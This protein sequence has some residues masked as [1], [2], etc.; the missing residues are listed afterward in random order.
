MRNLVLAGVSALA[1]GVL[2]SP[3]ADAAFLLIDDTDP[4]TITVTAGDFEGGFSIDGTELTIGL[5]ASASI[6]LPDGGYSISGSWLDLGLGGPRADVLFALTGTPSDVTSGIEF[7]T[8]TDGS[9]STLFGSL[10]GFTGSAYFFTALPTL[11]QGAVGVAGVPFLS[12]EFRSEPVA[13]V[14]APMSLALF[15][16]A[17][18]GLAGIRRRG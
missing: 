2:A 5:G 14:P 9:S 12:V 17:L 13:A 6:T 11:T 10:G 8:T 18:L 7:G 16:V 15:G 3:N 1:V 4:A